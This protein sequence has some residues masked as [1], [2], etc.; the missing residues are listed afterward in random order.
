MALDVLDRII[1]AARAKNRIGRVI[2][3]RTLQ[4]RLFLANHQQNRALL[5]LEDALTLAESA[6]YVRCFVDE[7]PSIAG[8]LRQMR[9]SGVEPTYAGQLLAAFQGVKHTGQAFGRLAAQDSQFL[10]DPLSQ[11]ELEILRL[12]ATGMSNRDLAETLVVTV[13][14][15]ASQ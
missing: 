2:E 7:G 10:L 3:A 13:G 9:A 8:L 15:V 14:T 1:D 4:S 6:G 12:I 11:R 5:A